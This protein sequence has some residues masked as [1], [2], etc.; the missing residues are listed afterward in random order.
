MSVRTSFDTV[1]GQVM[2]VTELTGDFETI[3]D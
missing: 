1:V 3:V 2:N